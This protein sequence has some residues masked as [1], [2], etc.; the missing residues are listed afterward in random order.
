MDETRY[1]VIQDMAY[2]E[3]RLTG[4]VTPTKYRYTD[5]L[6][7]AELDLDYFVARW[8]DPFLNHWILPYSFNPVPSKHNGLSD[9]SI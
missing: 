9:T 2:S 1:S 7:K 4:S 8:Y 5:Q 6:V 3:N